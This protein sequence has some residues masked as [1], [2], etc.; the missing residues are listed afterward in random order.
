MTTNRRVTVHPVSLL[1]PMSSQNINISNLSLNTFFLNKKSNIMKD[2]KKVHEFMGISWNM[3][4][5][6]KE[7]PKHNKKNDKIS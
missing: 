5:D 7:I 3:W 1:N 2:S 4:I 6:G